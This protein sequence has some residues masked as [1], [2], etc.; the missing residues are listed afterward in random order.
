MAC[1]MDVATRHVVNQHGPGR[2]AARPT[3]AEWVPWWCVATAASPSVL[4]GRIGLAVAAGSLRAH[5]RNNCQTRYIRTHAGETEGPTTIP[6]PVCPTSRN[7][8]AVRLATGV[9]GPALG[10]CR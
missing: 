1:C 4:I 9:L 6:A 2:Q 7:G 10:D 3:G 8:F 5:G